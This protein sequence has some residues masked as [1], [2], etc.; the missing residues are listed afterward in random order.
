MGRLRPATESDLARL[1]WLWALVYDGGGDGDGDE[2]GQGQGWALSA[3]D[4]FVRVVDDG[5]TARFPVVE[6]DGVIVATAIGTLELGV[7]NPYCASGRTVRLANVITVPEHRGHG[8][9]TL[10]VGDVVAWARS[11]DADRVDLSATPDGRGLYQRLGF[12]L[13]RAP[14]MKLVL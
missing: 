4:W 13:T 7:P 12:A 2:G 1:L 6:V 14:R 11:I 9:G 3:R 8:I 10:L 5:A